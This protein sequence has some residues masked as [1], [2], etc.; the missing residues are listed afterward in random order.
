MNEPREQ[1][2]LAAIL[3]ADVVGFSRLMEADE[4]GTL[5]AL[6]SCW[7]DVLSPCVAR[8]NGRVIKVMGDGVLVEFGSAVDAVECAVAMHAGFAAA[9][10]G[11]PEDRSI[12]LRIGINLGDVIVQGGDLYG[13]GVN[14]AARLEG[15][16]EPGGI[17]V[18]AKVHAEV[19][20]KVAIAFADMGEVALKNI[21]VPLR[22]YRVASARRAAVAVPAEPLGKPSIAVLAFQNMSG[23]P[24]QDYFADGVVEDIITALS[25]RRQLFVIARNSSF[26]YKGRAVDIKQVGRELGVR[27]VVEGSLRRAGDRLRISAQLI[28]ASTG[29]NLWAERHDGALAEVFD[30]Q[31]RIAAS[32]AGAILSTVDLAEIA[33]AQSKP[34]SGLDAYDH[35]LRGA[36]CHKRWT[37]ESIAEAIGHFRKA[38]DLDPAFAAAYGFA[39]YCHGSLRAISASTFTAENRDEA[40]RLALKAVE[41]A[42]ADDIVLTFASSAIGYAVGD[43][44]RGLLLGDRA[45]ALNPNHARAWFVQGVNRFYAG[46]FD[47]AIDHIR[48]AI[49]LNPQDPLMFVAE[50]VMA[51]A[52]F[53]AGRSDEALAWAE[54]ALSRRSANPDALLGRVVSLVGLGRDE[55]ARSAFGRY[56]D[57]DPNTTLRNLPFE[58]PFLHPTHLD[59]WTNALRQAG[60]PE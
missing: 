22:V 10:D 2:R 54:S 37:V 40:E 26:T 4:K 6:R 44:Q 41:L 50:T 20:G 9:N 13:D 28:D 58:M 56:S 8:H 35:Y 1:R 57:I 14:V 33:L 19:Q 17:C 25:R 55:E 18:S 12:I 5:A 11:V 51:Y 29:A 32:V 46:D 31:D 52:H 3:A 27:Y 53:T 23:D 48:R 34:P 45:L 24:E 43:V 16:A 7:K 36:A 30:L 38:I 21:A 59:L 15:L 49:Q 42:P 60:M 47:T 39:A